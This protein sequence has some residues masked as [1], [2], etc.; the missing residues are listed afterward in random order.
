MDKDSMGVD[1][2]YQKITQSYTNNRYEKMSVEISM[3][4]FCVDWWDLII[5]AKK[6][7]KN[8]HG[9]GNE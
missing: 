4:K 3:P 7:P 2:N 8:L 6:L 5:V 1:C 9:Y